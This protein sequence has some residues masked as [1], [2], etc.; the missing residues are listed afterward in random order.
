MYAEDGKRI[1]LSSNVALDAFTELTDLFQ[2]YRFPLTYEA[3]N[4]F[5]TGEMPILIQDYISLYNQLTVFAP[6]I[7]GLWEF[8]PLPGFVDEEGNINN[9][10]V[11]TVEGVCLMKGAEDNKE[12]SWRFLEWFTRASVQEAYS[13]E[14][15]AVVGQSSKNA[16]ANTE[17][18]SMLPWSAREYRNLKAQFD[19]TVGITE[20]PGAYIITRYIDFAFM[21]VYN[22]GA[23]ASDAMLDY[24]MNINKEISRKRKEFGFEYIDISKLSINDYVEQES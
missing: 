3:A 19:N 16:T 10:S 4:R 20:Y 8:A 17:A 13:N 23:N 6:E 1:N 11:V 21:D 7:D 9:C 24:V 12:D 14:L 15:V 22:K 2:S 18:L 5:R